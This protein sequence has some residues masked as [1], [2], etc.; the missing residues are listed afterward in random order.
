MAPKEKRSFLPYSRGVDPEALRLGSLYLNPLDPEDGLESKRFEY[1]EDLDQA[2]YEERIKP[3]IWKE[4][5]DERGFSLDFQVTKDNSMGLK[6]SDIVKGEANAGSTVSAV[7]EGKSGRRLKIK[8]PEKFLR[9]EVITQTRVQEWIRTQASIAF[10]GHFGMHKFKAPEIWMVTGV[11]LVTAGDVQVGSSRSVG[12]SISA[13][14]DPGLAFGA[15][16]GLASVGVHASHNHGSEANHGYGYEDERVWAAQFMEVKIEYGDEEDK[17]VKAKENKLVP[18][19]ISTFRLEDIADL[20]ARGIRAT[21]RQRVEVPKLIGRIVVED[22]DDD[23]AD[24]E[25]DDLHLSDQPYVEVLKDTDW[26]MYDECS[27]YLRDAE[28][29][30][31]SVSQEP[32]LAG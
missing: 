13:H 27:K 1:Q 12:A 18:A 10:K 4:Q 14:V 19:T 31:T 15:P 28:T 2:E 8:K 21:Q 24:A 11:Q 26:D 25:S 20:K 9:D 29:G 22:V 5:K 17:T 30:G 6:L 16:P 7:L 23:D 32:I 3:W